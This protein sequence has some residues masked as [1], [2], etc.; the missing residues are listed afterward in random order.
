MTSAFRSIALMIIVLLTLAHN[1]LFYGVG[2]SINMILFNAL[3]LPVVINVGFLRRERISF[4]HGLI[5]VLVLILSGFLGMGQH[6]Y[7]GI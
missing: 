7:D 5:S 3:L 6:C 4:L 1:Y 2:V